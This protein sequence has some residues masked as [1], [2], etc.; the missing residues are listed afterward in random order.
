MQIANRGAREGFGR[1]N[2]RHAIGRVARI[3]SK[4]GLDLVR[5]IKIEAL[6]DDRSTA[7]PAVTHASPCY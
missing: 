7:V 5:P 2:E 6:G 3:C 1:G 4:D